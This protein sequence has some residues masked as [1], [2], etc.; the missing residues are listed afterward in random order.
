[1]KKLLLLCL[2]GLSVNLQA[3]EYFPYNGVRDE[4]PSEVL[5]VNAQ[6]VVQAGELIPNGQLHIRDGK[7]VQ[8]GKEL[9]LPAGVRVVDLKG[10]YIYP[11]FVEPYGEYGIAAAGR[12]STGRGGGPQMV[13]ERTGAYTANDAIR[14]DQQAA[15]LFEPNDKEAENWRKMGYGA[16]AIHQADGIVRGTGALVATGSESANRMLL[17]PTLSAHFS[18]NKG[19]SRQDYPSSLMGSIALLRQSFYDAAWYDQNRATAGNDLSLNALLQQQKLP[20]IFESSQKYDPLRIHKIGQEFKL[21]FIV[22]GRGD[23]YQYL[24]AIKAAGMP[25]IIPINF[26]DAFDVE[27]PL[28]ARDVSLAQ[29]LHWELAPGNPAALHKAGIPF[30]ISS[31]GLKKTDEFLANVR[32]AIDYGLSEQAALE[33]LTLAPARLLQAHQLVGS[34]QAGRLANFMICSG[35]IFDE[36]TEW[37]EHWVRGQPYELSPMPENEDIRGV[38]RLSAGPLDG[39]SIRI[40]G[41]W[42]KPEASLELDDSTTIKLKLERNGNFVTLW[43]SD[44][45]YEDG[46]PVRMG[47]W[48]KAD[49]FQGQISLNEGQRI[50]FSLLREAEIEE[51]EKSEKEKVAAVPG[52]LRYPFSDWGFTQLPKA[53]NLII[54]RA[55]V[56]TSE[57]EGKLDSTD[58]AIKDG[59]I[60]AIGK[61]LQGSLFGKGAPFRELEAT[62]MHLTPGFID[63]HSHIAI[64]RGVNEG[65]RSITSEVRIGDVLNPDDVNIYRQLAGGVTGANLLHG[66]ANSIGGQAQFIKLRWGSTHPEALKFKEAPG[67]IKFALGENVKQSNWG[68]RNTVRFPQTRMGVEQIVMDGFLRAKAYEAERKANPNGVRR[69]LSLDALVEIM[70]QERFI[71][72]HSYVQSEINMLMKAADSLGFQVNTFTHILEGYKVADKMFVHG[73]N[74][75]TFADWW[76]YKYEV[77]DAIPQNAAIMNRV[78]VN[79]A[80]NSDDAEMARRLNQEAAKTVKYGGMSEEE[81]LRMVTL[82]PA[83]ALRVDAYTGSIQKGKQADLV[84]WNAHPL[85]MYSKPSYTFVDGVLL[86]DRQAEEARYVELQAERQRLINKMLEAKQKG[87]KTSKPVMMMEPDW[88]CETLGE[89]GEEGD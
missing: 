56:W 15:A 49:G 62:G 26:P 73:A 43:F 16:V 78:G 46:R 53:E 88:H 85:S 75:S 86:Y 51:K 5:F 58:V 28:D 38:Y 67:F 7:V 8:V 66:S 17:Q 37:Y 70:N 36:D 32:L 44:K 87:K 45:T 1:M 63:E 33:A 84:I 22:T 71:T 79:V 68:E 80:I 11:A 29:M 20:L 14:A 21:A 81:A 35:P 57:A 31:K 74:A 27:D 3:Q 61:N 72:C 54:R 77:V 42:N 19:S 9:K 48:R 13:P 39:K 40:K 41:K 76:A 64:T 24:D 4:R 60:W 6:I 23:E 69:D 34:L 65:T 82:N 12:S 89:L 30:A 83:K 18:F 10:K 55:T 59:K 47:V 50:D 52:L 25:L 2:L